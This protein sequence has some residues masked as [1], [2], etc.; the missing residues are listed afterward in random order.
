MKGW[1]V[2]GWGDVDRGI[3]IGWCVESQWCGWYVEGGVWGCMHA[4]SVGS[5]HSQVSYLASKRVSSCL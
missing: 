5:C 2:E 1:C 4:T 3:H